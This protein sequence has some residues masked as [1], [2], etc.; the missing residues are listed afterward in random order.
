MGWLRR[1]RSTV[2]RSRQQLEIEE[3]LRFH[4]EQRAEESMRDGMS[5][6]LARQQ[7]LRR[8][9]NPALIRERTEDADRFGWLGDLVDD[10][11]YGLRMMRRHPSFSVSALL[12][13]ALGIG[14]T[15][16][17][18]SVVYG[19]LLRPLP[20]PS[21]ERLVRV[22]EEH[23]GGTTMGGERWISNRTYWAW[24]ER[25]RT[26][27]VL[28]AY[29]TF[30]ATIRV[31]DD[32][33][34]VFGAQ[35]SPALMPALGVAP[36]AGRLFTAGEAEEGANRVVLLGE[37]LWV[38]RFNR[39]SGIIGR[40][41]RIEGEPH[42]VIGVLPRRFQFPS[43]DETFWR[44]Y[45]IARVS[46]DP[47]QAQR[48]SGMTAMAR[49]AP[50][51]TAAQ[52]EAEGTALARSVPVTMATKALFG[53][54]GPPVVHVQP[55]AADMTGRVRPVLLVL[56]AAVGALLLIA[57]ANVANMF[58][59]RGLARQR[60]FAVRASIGA[61]RSRL[62]RQLLTE[63]FVLSVG[64]AILGLFLAWLLLR[65]TPLIAPAQFPRL[66][67]VYLD[68]QALAFTAGAT[69]MTTLLS[70]LLPALRGARFNVAA[71]LRGGSG[72]T[73]GGFHGPRDRRLRDV[74]LVAESA[75]ALMLIV[76][77]M[78]LVRS[79]VSLTS[80]DPG[81]RPERV[82]TAHVMMPHGSKPDRSDRFTSE[83]LSR[84]RALAGVASAGAGNMMPMF[85]RQAVATF[86]LPDPSG[87][88]PEVTARAT[89]YMITPGYI[90]ALG[91]RL[92]A[93]RSFDE[94]DVQSGTRAMLVN[95]LF[96]R[97]Y[98]GP[99]P[100]VGRRF[101]NLFRRIDK[102]VVTEIVGVVA[103]MLKDGNDSEPQ[104]EVY[105]VAKPQRNALGQSVSFVA[106]T[107]GDP[108]ALVAAVRAELRDLDRDVIIDSVQPLT[109]PLAA[110]VAQPRFATATV[111][112]FALLALILASIGLYGVL[113][114]AVSQRGRELGVRAALGASRSSLLGLVLRE[115]LVVATCGVVLGIGGAAAIS[116]LM[117][118]A[119]FGVTPLDPISFAMA[120][121]V[122]LPVAFAACL[123]PALRA[124]RI[125][126]AEA[127]RE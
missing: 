87:V 69:L 24:S 29:G 80:V 95:E 112:T 15:S 99:G 3:E 74:L 58:L 118:G 53:V 68:R 1:L 35:V 124:S 9:G 108:R 83:A 121:A 46:T 33:V 44:P 122:L 110:S 21:A 55:L 106:R 16:T 59:T 76:A 91:V 47:E 49:L 37:A 20:Y 88:S 82:V 11:K 63:T 25:P 32:D 41:V 42:T 23:P 43:A 7:A 117:Q 77:A 92:R 66:A 107:T 64:G 8:F 34:S 45:I 113:S 84:V 125:G 56:A 109:V 97:R 48:T 78:L 60:E 6:D 115:G 4:I 79:F 120:P 96:A 17:V 18:F 28:G 61:G 75:F 98:L 89:S 70:G 51:S 94:S 30:A 38:E 90:E 14:A 103:P 65:I 27:D 111:T 22:W 26:I 105:F 67:D 54:G 86:P 19:V 85:P 71:S 114:Y 123:V 40:T 62:V 102:G 10:A 36:L 126:P 81:Y 119:L 50:G 100:V 101:T 73:A 116:R 52:V 72:A 57:C 5:A 12:T 31:G 13:L 2:L 93:G 39:D 104:S 127:L